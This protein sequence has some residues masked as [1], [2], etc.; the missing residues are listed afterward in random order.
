MAQILDLSKRF[1]QEQIEGAN[2]SVSDLDLPADGYICRILEPILH[3]D[4][5]ANKANI[6]LR[7]DIAEGKYKDYFQR[8]EDRFGFW[9]LRG[10]MSFKESQLPN[11][12][13]TCV[14][15]CN[16]N[17]GLKFNPFATGG[18]DIDML[19]GKLIGVVIGK[20]EY[21]NSSGD[22]REKNVVSFFCETKKI[23]EHKFKIPG[24][25]RLTDEAFGTNTAGTSNLDIP[26]EG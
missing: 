15:L 4:P 25:K 18:V 1:T 2:Q 11:F 26:F 14:A 8:L 10:W 20:E 9:G 7:I 17:P 19:K 6:E 23:K 24:V 13:R 3:D 22:K 5:D 12:Q 16:S 21:R